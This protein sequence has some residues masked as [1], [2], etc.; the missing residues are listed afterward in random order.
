PLA[1]SGR[2]SGR[3]HRELEAGCGHG[4]LVLAPGGRVVVACS[5][6]AADTEAR[7]T[8]PTVGWAARA[9]SP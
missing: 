2:A 1:N 8:D 6:M 4:V 3:G 5:L 7:A 9:A